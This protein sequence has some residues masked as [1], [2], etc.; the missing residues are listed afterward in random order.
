LELIDSAWRA[1][2]DA[3]KFQTY[4]TEK[5]VKRESPLFAILK[6]CEL[7]FGSFHRLKLRADELGIDFFSTPFDDESLNTLESLNVKIHKIASFDVTNMKLLD[8]V[9]QTGKAIVISTGMASLDEIK[10]AY[11]IIRA[12]TNEIAILHCVSAYPLAESNA[13]LAV[14]ESLRDEFDCIIGYSDHTNGIVV[15][16]YA[17]SAGAQIIEKHYRIDDEMDCVDAPVSIT[18]I[19]MKKFIQE[20]N[21]IGKIFGSNVIGSCSAENETKLYR[22]YDSF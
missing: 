20:A 18:E 8:R 10:V 14:I 9:S 15:P 13:N 7:P 12:K 3:V 2:A 16:L 6:K 11:D 22:R 1:G 17:V 5:R 21:R 19:Q 4:I